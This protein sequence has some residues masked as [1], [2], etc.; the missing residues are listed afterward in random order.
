[1]FDREKAVATEE[2]LKGREEKATRAAERAKRKQA[3]IS[4]PFWILP[5]GAVLRPDQIASIEPMVKSWEQASRPN[6]LGKA[7]V[8]MIGGTNYV[9]L[10]DLHD[11]SALM[12]AMMTVSE[13]VESATLSGDDSDGDG[14]A[15]EKK[16]YIGR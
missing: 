15:G 2:E 6:D 8:Q 3:L 10:S 1:M 11:V 4:A 16:R 13:E 7:V 14:V 12:S 5:S 9:T